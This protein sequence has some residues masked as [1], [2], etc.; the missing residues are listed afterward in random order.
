VFITRIFRQRFALWFQHTEYILVSLGMTM[1][2]ET[3]FHSVLRNIANG[4]AIFVEILKAPPTCSR[5][6]RVS[7]HHVDGF[8]RALDEFRAL[9]LEDKPVCDQHGS[10]R[11][12]SGA[13]PV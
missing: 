5:V 12:M 13:I 10:L 11:K 4:V 2:L 6:T 8:A 7:Y 3:C 1:A 9:G